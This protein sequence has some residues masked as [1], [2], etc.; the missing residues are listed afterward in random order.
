M[1]I[2]HK[3]AKVWYLEIR[4]PKTRVIEDPD[5]KILK[6]FPVEFE[7]YRKIYTE[8]GGQWNWANRLILNYIELKSILD[9]PENEIYYCYYKGAFVGYFELD[10][11]KEDVELVYFGLSPNYI[12]KGLGNI[13]IQG[14]IRKVQQLNSPRLWLHTCEF[15]SPQA[16]SFYIK[17]GFV[18]FNEKIETQV[19]IE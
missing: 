8:V 2:R 7:Q 4:N 18:V 12:G 9:D 11:H 15:D 6:Q 16:L 17:S 13:M 1:K 19:I 3:A 10:L 14:V 5:F